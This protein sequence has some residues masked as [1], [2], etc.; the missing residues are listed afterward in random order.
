MNTC[1]AVCTSPVTAVKYGTS[2]LFNGVA[3]NCQTAC[4]DAN[5]YFNSTLSM[6]TCNPRPSVNGGSFGCQDAN[7]TNHILDMLNACMQQYCQS[8]DPDVG[9]CPFQNVTYD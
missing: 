6:V 1:Q 9:G 2:C 4:S 3:S 8:P 5:F 7:Y